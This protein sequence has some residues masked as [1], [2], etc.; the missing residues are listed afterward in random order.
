MADYVGAV[1]LSGVSV[2]VD[3]VGCSEALEVVRAKHGDHLLH[4]TLAQLGVSRQAGS[5]QLT[6]E[7]LTLLAK[8]R[9]YN[10]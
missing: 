5:Q 1:G 6:F 3:G 4:V 2:T 8:A 7:G 9:P 10:P